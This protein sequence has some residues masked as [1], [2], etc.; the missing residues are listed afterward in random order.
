M[1]LTEG[2]A[3]HDPFFS[4]MEESITSLL[5]Y[6]FE[7]LFEPFPNEYAELETMQRNPQV[8]QFSLDVFQKAFMELPEDARAKQVFNR[9]S[10][11]SLTPGWEVSDRRMFMH[12]LF[13][14]RRRFHITESV[15]HSEPTMGNGKALLP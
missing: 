14:L 7:S 13:G 8:F 12:T 10:F 4:R 2:D 3:F 15:E 6:Y 1:N 11:V 5:L 9:T